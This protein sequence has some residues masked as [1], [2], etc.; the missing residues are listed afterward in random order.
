MSAN[1]LPPLPEDVQQC[2]RIIADLQSH[3][4]D[5]QAHATELAATLDEQQRRALRLQVQVELLL[6]RLYGPR[7][8]R[9]DPAQLVM[10]GDQ[11]TAARFPRLASLVRPK[12]SLIN[13][14]RVFGQRDVIKIEDLTVHVERELDSGL[15]NGQ[16]GAL[17]GAVVFPNHPLPIR[18]PFH[19][20]FRQNP[21]GK[22]DVVRPRR[23]EPV[24]SVRLLLVLGSVRNGADNPD[25]R[26]VVDHR[27]VIGVRLRRIGGLQTQRRSSAL[28][29][30]QGGPNAFEFLSGSKRDDVVLGPHIHSVRNA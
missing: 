30:E 28:K 1:P 3:N 6:K 10:F 25:L 16:D 11:V 7:A 4:T 26:L 21:V 23:N 18:L 14:R 8:E 20:S 29:F 9:I 5:L 27:W 12:R 15:M 2:H 19:D 17:I 13:Y 24:C 22:A